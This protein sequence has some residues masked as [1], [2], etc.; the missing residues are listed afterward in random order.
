MVPNACL[1]VKLMMIV[2]MDTVSAVRG[3]LYVA[4][5]TAMRIRA[6]ILPNRCPVLEFANRKQ[7]ILKE[8]VTAHFAERDMKESVN[9]AA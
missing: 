5:I 8:S 4:D 2:R 9:E 1:L 7:T 3:F 6:R